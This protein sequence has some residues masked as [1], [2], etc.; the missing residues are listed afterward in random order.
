MKIAK[1]FEFKLPKFTHFY[2]FKQ[3]TDSDKLSGNVIII[4][5]WH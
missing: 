5:E 2:S 4:N 3:I 1:S